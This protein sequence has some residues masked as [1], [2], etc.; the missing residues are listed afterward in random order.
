MQTLDDA[1]RLAL[2]LPEVS[3]GVRHGNRA[4]TV[5]G[6]TFAWERPFS[7]ADRKRYGTVTPPDGDILAISAA[8][9]GEKEAILAGNPEAFFSIEHFNNYPAY[10]VHLNRVDDG[11]LA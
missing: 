1:A 11:A 5:A 4:W 8:D 9:L 6:K 2:E 7:K 10:L 3:E